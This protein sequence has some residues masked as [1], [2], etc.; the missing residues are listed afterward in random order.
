V[1]RLLF[2]VTPG[3][4][5]LYYG[6]DAT[7]G[8]LYDLESLKGHLGLSPTFGA[9]TLGAEEANSRFRRMPPLPF[10]APRGVTVAVA[11]WQKIHRLTIADREDL[12][13]LILSPEDL[14]VAGPKFGDLRIVDE[15]DR[16]VPYALEPAASA[17]PVA[18]TVE[19]TGGPSRSGGGAVSRYRLTVRS[20]APRS[21][22]ALPIWALELTFQEEFFTRRI[23]LFA[24][25]PPHGHDTERHLYTGPLER[26]ADVH[27][28]IPPGPIVLNLS[29]MR[30]REL[31][32]D[33]DEGDNTPLTLVRAEAVVRVPRVAF[34]AAPGQY[35]LLV[36]NDQ[37]EPPR[38]D[39]AS[40]QQEMLSY[41]AV[42]V[43]AGPIEPNPAFRRQA[44]DYVRSVSP[45]LLLWGTLVGAVS[46]L[47]LLTVRILKVS[48]NRNTRDGYP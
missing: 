46:V 38:Y 41:S 25:P 6:N 11:H 2:P 10:A 23:R 15:S 5:T 36:G 8:P 42:A 24:P 29:G 21:P 12:Y 37:V 26:R 32:L 17:A 39:I 40:L 22:L 28:S 13:T 30:E 7:R 34:K 16:Q 48:P 1:T 44:R 35:R 4:L 19:R 20:E 9:A 45:S 31:F 47:L 33:I 18:M 14:A 43:H 27:G 3:P